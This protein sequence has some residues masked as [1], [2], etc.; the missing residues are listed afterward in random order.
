MVDQALERLNERSLLTFGL[1]GQAVTC[2]AWWREW[3]AAGWP[4]GDGLAAACRA[5][6][7]ALEASAE[8][9]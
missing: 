3:S 5:A 4:G 9:S 6:A 7:S 2:T 1:D 8:A